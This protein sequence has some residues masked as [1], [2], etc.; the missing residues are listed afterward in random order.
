MKDFIIRN[1]EELNEKIENIK[2][3]G[4]SKLHVVSDFDR[5]LTPA[6]VEGQK[7]PTVIARIREGKYLT[8]DYPAKAYAL[9]DEYYPIE[10]AEDI[11]YE[12]KVKKMHEWWSRHLKLIVES[13]MNKKVIEDI[14]RKRTLH[15]RKGAKELLELL[16]K[17]K[18]PI[19]IFSAALGDIIEGS[20]KFEGMFHSN[21]HVI[22]DFF[23]FDENGNAKGYKGEIIHV[24]N[25]NEG[26]IKKSPYYEK[27]KER[28]NVIL[29]G[30]SLGDSE[31]LEGLV[32]ETIIKIGFLNENIEKQKEKFLKEY[33]VLILNDGTMDYVSELLE[34]II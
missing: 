4:V 13:G 11:P 26:Q 8:H 22:S 30:D 12:K 9:H 2:K 34:K 24:F 16:A 29:L 15:Y 33:D 20:L 28:K 32:H 5:T 27:I 1:E 31:M 10:I 21:I 23:E 18:I 6:F 3:D 7:T 17:H 19:L 25:K 14:V